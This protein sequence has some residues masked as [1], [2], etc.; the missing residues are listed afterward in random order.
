[1]KLNNRIAKIKELLVKKLDPDKI[2]IFGSVVKDSERIPR[3]IDIF[4]QGGRQ[5][6]HRDE[7]KLREEIDEIAGIYTV[8]LLFSEKVEDDFKNIV[9]ETGIVIY[10]KSRG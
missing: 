7:R 2:I 4:I 10:E 1:M 8:D 3:D 9:K 6:T 5:L